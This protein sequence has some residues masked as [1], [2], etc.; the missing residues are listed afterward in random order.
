[1][2]VSLVSICFFRLTYVNIELPLS[3][4]ADQQGEKQSPIYVS[5]IKGLYLHVVGYREYQELNRRD[6]EKVLI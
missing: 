2:F 3:E 1:M 6:V 4:N 5:C